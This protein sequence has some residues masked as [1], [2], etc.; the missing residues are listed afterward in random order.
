MKKYPP[1]FYRNTR[2]K[3]INKKSACKLKFQEKNTG[4]LP[5]IIYFHRLF[6]FIH[7]IL[8]YRFLV[9]LLL[10]FFLLCTNSRHDFFFFVQL[11]LWYLPC[12]QK[13]YNDE[14]RLKN[15]T[16]LIEFP[17]WAEVLARKIK[18]KDGYDEFK[19]FFFF[20]NSNWGCIHFL[21]K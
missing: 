10:I 18:M 12:K 16:I 1:K 21:V 8:H 20:R 2:F 13:I 6:W 4:L 11:I 3:R 5:N 17:K 9:L 7:I 19:W 14:N 15:G